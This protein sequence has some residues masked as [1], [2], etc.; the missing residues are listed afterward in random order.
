MYYLKPAHP[1]PTTATFFLNPSLF[2]SNLLT[3]TEYTELCD[4]SSIYKGL[5]YENAFA[6]VRNSYNE[7]LPAFARSTAEL[8][9]EGL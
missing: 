5:Q 9:S 7:S 3:E 4:A 6:D 1:D 2:K 8:T